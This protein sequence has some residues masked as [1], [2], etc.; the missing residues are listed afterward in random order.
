MNTVVIATRVKLLLPQQVPVKCDTS[1]T[2]IIG[3]TDW[4]KEK[5][6]YL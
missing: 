4:L 2:C 1:V 6:N 5:Q 3:E